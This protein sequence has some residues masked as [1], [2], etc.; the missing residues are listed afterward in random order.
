M[1]FLLKNMAAASMI[2][3]DYNLINLNIKLYGNFKHGKKH[4]KQEQDWF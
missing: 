3:K 1:P 4:N 2:K